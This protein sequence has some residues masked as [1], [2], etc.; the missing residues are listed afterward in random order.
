MNEERTGLW[1]RQTEHTPGHLWPSFA[2]ST[3]YPSTQVTFWDVLSVGSNTS[4]KQYSRL[5]N[6]WKVIE[7][8]ISLLTKSVPQEGIYN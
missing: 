2:M 1:L 6:V 4:V 3:A 5:I 8:E 7:I